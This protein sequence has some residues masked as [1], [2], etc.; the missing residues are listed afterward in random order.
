MFKIE[1]QW[2]FCIIAITGNELMEPYINPVINWLIDRLIGALI[3]EKL[4][5]L[6]HDNLYSS[7]IVTQ[8]LRDSFTIDRPRAEWRMQFL[9]EKVPLGSPA[10]NSSPHGCTRTLI[11]SRSWY[12]FHRPE[13]DGSLSQA[14]KYLRCTLIQFFLSQYMNPI[15]CNQE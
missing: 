11:P 14:I 12:S 10:H 13:K 15:Y 4:K 7:V 6:S 3:Q 1:N 9:N 5:K 2:S 8:L